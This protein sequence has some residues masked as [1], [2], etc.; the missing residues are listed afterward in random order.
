MADGHTGALV[1][2]GGT[3]VTAR[4]RAQ[5][6]LVLQ[7]GAVA[8][9]VGC[10][11]GPSGARSLDVDGLFVLPGFVDTHV[12]LMD[13]GDASRED[14]PSGTRAALHQ[15]VTTVV[16]HT[17]GWPVT[18]VERL[19][20]KVA[21]LRGRSWVDYGLA[22]HVWP[23]RIG[24]IGPL[25]EEGAVFFKIF[26]CTT[27]GVPGLPTD[28]LHEALGAIARCGGAALVHCED[29][30]MT[31]G[32]E[33]RLR[34][35]GRE[36]PWILPE[37]RSRA[38]EIVAATVVCLMARLTGARTTIAH[39]SSPDIVDLVAEEAAR[40]TDVRAESCPQYLLMREDDIVSEGS[41]RKFTPPARLRSDAEQQAMWSAFNTGRI[42]HLSTD[43]APS[44]RQHK[45]AGS[46]WDVHFGLPGLDTT[47]GLMIDAALSG[48]TSLEKVVEAYA[49]A[50][51][52]RYR[53]VGKGDL[54]PGF[55]ADV[56]LVDPAATWTVADTTVR[57]KAGWSP[58]SGTTLRGRV[59]GTVVGGE[60]R[61]L[62]GD[63]VAGEGAGRLV[64]GAGRRA[65][66]GRR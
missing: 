26:T 55:D 50:P 57:S 58:Y 23:D 43:H 22:A 63:E 31:A 17:H 62:Q 46:L 16:E 13:P 60:L 2:R 44:T 18:S 52:R 4:G 64:T 34:A 61:M 51:A 8:G 10:G 45:A 49:T 39:A 65:A 15:G 59:V 6:N 19:R 28:L 38:A 5:G 41:L 35:A 56:A 7:D 53:L 37:W 11:E 3:V 42:H 54:L 36:D 25:W 9:V 29:E 33:A 27:H 24:D 30:A 48:V 32:A 47:A 40:G 14:F 66:G 20:E 1:L 12:H 21:H